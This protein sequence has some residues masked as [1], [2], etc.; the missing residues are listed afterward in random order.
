MGRTVEELE[1]SVIDRG[2]VVTRKA[3][4]FARGGSLVHSHNNR[5]RKKEGHPLFFAEL[6]EEGNIYSFPA[7]LLLHRKKGRVC[8]MKLFLTNVPTDAMNFVASRLHGPAKVPLHL[9]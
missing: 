8:E 1:Q 5:R 7:L 9:G 4:G 3:E 2:I 6:K